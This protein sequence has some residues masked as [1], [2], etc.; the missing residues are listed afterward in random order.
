MS[1]FSI[2]IIHPCEGLRGGLLK[3]GP[4]CDAEERLFFDGDIH[5]L[6][7]YRY[8]LILLYFID[9]IIHQNLD[10]K[11]EKFNNY[12][13][14]LYSKMIAYR[15]NPSVRSLLPSSCDFFVD[16]DILVKEIKKG[17]WK[18]IIGNDELISRIL[19]DRDTRVYRRK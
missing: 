3:K 16:V 18:S 9:T 11:H 17:R 14:A 7:S 8:H 13:E 19:K 6:C 1:H 10:E 15:N 5:N 12:R 2:L 4:L